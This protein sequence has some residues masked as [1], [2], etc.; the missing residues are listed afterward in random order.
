M[1][2]LFSNNNK[3]HPQK[4]PKV[5]FLYFQKFDAGIVKRPDDNRETPVRGFRKS[6][7]NVKKTKLII[8]LR[9]PITRMI[10]D[11]TQLASRNPDVRPLRLLSYLG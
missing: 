9:D 7:I 8:V 2:K 4:S 10:S 6:F 3:N 5:C 11:Y 1:S